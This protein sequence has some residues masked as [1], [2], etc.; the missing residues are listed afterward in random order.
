[1]DLRLERDVLPDSN[2][3][4]LEFMSD[5]SLGLGIRELRSFW[6]D[7]GFEVQDSGSGSFRDFGGT[8]PLCDAVNENPHARFEFYDSGFGFRVSGSGFRVPGFRFRVLGSGFRA[9]SSRFRFQVAGRVC[10]CRVPSRWD[11]ADHSSFGFLVSSTKNRVHGFRHK[12]SGGVRVAGVGP[13]ST[14]RSMRAFMPGI[15][16][17]TPSSPKRFV[18]PYLVARNDSKCDANVSRSYLPGSVSP[19]SVGSHLTHLLTLSLKLAFDI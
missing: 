18:T 10:S 5:K 19:S 4:Q 1:M 15:D 3:V 11:T 2:H 17:S 12:V 8:M 14:A 13:I 7:S 6:K 16:D 9:S